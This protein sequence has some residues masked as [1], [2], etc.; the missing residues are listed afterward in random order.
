MQGL[1]LTSGLI[2]ALLSAGL[3]FWIR[4][5]L[6]RRSLRDAERKLAYVHF[7]G[8]S[9][10]VA[11]EIVATSF[12]KNLVGQRAQEALRSKDGAFEPSHK[13]SAM[14]AKEI[15]KLTPEKLKEMPGLSIIPIFLRSQLEAMSDSNL[16]AEE[17]SKLPKET[18]LTYSLFLRYLSH[19]RGVVLLWI[20]FFEK[21]QTLWVTPE[22]IHD[23]WLAVT[24]LFKHARR[25]R[26][27]LLVA[28]ATSA[29]EANA[30]LQRQVS[31]YNEE[32]FAKFQHQKKLHDAIVETETSADAGK[33]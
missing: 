33:V 22:A 14:I 23:Q 4:A 32:M 1:A 21:Q 24:K 11:L 6:D 31:T 20:A 16:T 26:T 10:L 28:G 30:L 9:E 19:L 27:A 18:V 13:L 17:L 29:S 7:V 25:L 8:I 15:Q 12:I 2:G 5:T 3:S